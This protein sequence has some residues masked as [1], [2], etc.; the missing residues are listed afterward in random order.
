VDIVIHVLNI[1]KKMSNK[2]FKL[3]YNIHNELKGLNLPV[4]EKIS[5]MNTLIAMT[6]K[7]DISNYEI[8]YKKTQINNYDK[9]I[10]EV[11]GID[12]C[13]VFIYKKPTKLKPLKS[14]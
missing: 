6:Y 7:V 2:G 4:E 13:P 11:I 9:P 10:K 8:F 12:E 3:Q 5:M 14:I 1:I